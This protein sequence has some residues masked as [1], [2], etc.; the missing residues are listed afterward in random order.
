MKKSVR[1]IALILALATVFALVGCGKQTGGE[2]ETQDTTLAEGQTFAPIPADK[3]KIGVVHITSKDDTSGYTYA[4]QKGIEEMA[5]A[6]GLKSE[7]IV[8]RDN[9]DDN[10]V[11]ATKAALQDLVD[12]GCDVIFATSYNYMDAVEEYAEKYPD[13][14]FSHC[15][16]Y[17]SN[18]KNFNN[19]FGRIYEARYLS[20]IAAGLKAKE[21]GVPIVGFVGAKGSDNSEVTGGIN[22]F[23]LGVQSVYPECEVLVKITGEWYDP[24]AEGIAAKALIDAG[25]V[26]LAQHCDS[27]TVQTTAAQAGRF[28]V[29]YNSDMTPSA[30][31]N[32][33]TAPIWNWGVYYTQTVEAIIK[34]EWKCENYYEGYNVNLVGLSPLN[35][36]AIAPGTKEA[37][38][39]AQKKIAS[40]EL[41]VFSG[42][43]YDNQGN[44][45]L[46]EGEK[47]TD[48]QITGGINYYIKGVRVL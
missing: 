29:G 38:E 30:P 12:A 13:I 48:E 32:H 45:I 27:D 34:G 41:F 37:V 16:G 14:I 31:N 8:I 1:I 2:G 33:L 20:G 5:A 9:V 40:G 19:Y 3:I 24:A 7:Q 36:K 25:A 22:A 23:A 39:E 11:E 28:G 35:E 47:L 4:H 42:P 10:D 46:K 15:S 6:L 18:G 17:K 44:Q 43:L 26:V 21:L